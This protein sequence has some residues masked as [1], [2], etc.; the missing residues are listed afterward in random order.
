[1]AR[2]CAYVLLCG[3][4]GEL[5]LFCTDIEVKPLHSC[6]KNAVEEAKSIHTNESRLHSRDPRI[7]CI[8]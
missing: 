8:G 4:G 2:M 6:M 1:M 3:D 7:R 5:Y